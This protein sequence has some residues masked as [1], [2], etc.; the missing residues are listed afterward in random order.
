MSNRFSITDKNSQNLIAYM[1]N[2]L[3]FKPYFFSD[4][5]TTLWM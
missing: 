4:L 1:R 2:Y 3:Y 5:Y